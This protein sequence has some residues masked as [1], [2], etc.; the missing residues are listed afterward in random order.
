MAAAHPRPHP[1]GDERLRGR[2]SGDSGERQERTMGL[3]LIILGIFAILTGL[4][5][6][7]KAA[8]SKGFAKVYW[9]CTLPLGL[10]GALAVG[11]GL[12]AFGV[13]LMI[14]GV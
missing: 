10:T 6:S 7:S 14:N 3:L 12:I 8:K 2:K 4:D 1:A 9:G 11:T 5:Y 13:Y